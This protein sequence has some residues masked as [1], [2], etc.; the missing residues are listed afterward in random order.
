MM[1]RG[2]GADVIINVLLWVLGWIPGVIRM[3]PPSKRAQDCRKLTN[4][5]AWYIISR[6]EDNKRPIV[7]QQPVVPVQQQP[8][9][10]VHKY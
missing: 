3:L 5:D 6:F 10:P 1:K 9:Q 2:C 7:V 4:V 8:V